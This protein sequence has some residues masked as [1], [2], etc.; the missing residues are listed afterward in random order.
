[1][2]L[3]KEYYYVYELSVLL[4]SQI[5][6]FACNCIIYFIVLIFITKLMTNIINL[7]FNDYDLAFY[8]HGFNKIVIN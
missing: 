4:L 7:W 3:I 6:I 8:C 5:L 1:V 2:L